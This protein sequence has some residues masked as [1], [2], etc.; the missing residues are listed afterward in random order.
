MLARVYIEHE[1][2]QRTFQP[3]AQAQVHHKACSCNLGGPLEIQNAQFGPKIPVRLH[4]E[5]ESRR[6]APT[7]HF[8]VIS[9][10]LAHRNR[11]LRKVGNASQHLPERFVNLLDVVFQRGNALA[12]LTH[13]ELV[14]RG[15]DALL[16]QLA[17]FD[18][19]GIP[20]RFELFGFRQSGAPL[21]IRLTKLFHIKGEAPGRQSCCDGVQVRSKE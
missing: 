5:V 12:D 21:H 2:D 6:S 14:F 16:A 20:Q 18:T 15:I 8:H 19:L 13:F 4:R 3:R 10:I 7:A 11:F 9:G 17:Y 1:V